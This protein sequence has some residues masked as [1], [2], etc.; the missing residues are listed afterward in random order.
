[1]RSPGQV[2]GFLW[3]Y[4]NKSVM[5]CDGYYIYISFTMS[6][7]IKTGVVKTTLA[8]LGSLWPFHGHIRYD[9]ED[10]NLRRKDVKK[11]RGYHLFGPITRITIFPANKPLSWNL[12]QEIVEWSAGPGHNLKCI[13]ISRNGKIHYV[14][15]F[16]SILAFITPFSSYWSHGFWRM[17]KRDWIKS[18]WRVEGVKVVIRHNSLCFMYLVSIILKVIAMILRYLFVPHHSR[19]C[20]NFHF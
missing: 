18:F 20:C 17:S 15:S 14:T 8:H 16:M 13:S 2:R 5:S 19:Q 7:R 10:T 12:G 6:D 3:I 1:M 4:I 9:S 11:Y